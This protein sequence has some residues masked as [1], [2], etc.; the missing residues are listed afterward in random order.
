MD[1]EVL[2]FLFCLIPAIGERTLQVSCYPYGINHKGVD[3]DDSDPVID[4]AIFFLINIIEFINEL[5]E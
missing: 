2:T 3:D 4:Q 1:P 5:A